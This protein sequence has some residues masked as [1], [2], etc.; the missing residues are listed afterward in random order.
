MSDANITN[1]GSIALDTITNDGTDITLDSSGDIVL[2]ADGA[3]IL[4][5]DDGTTFGALVND[6]GKLDIK[7]GSTPSTAI[8]IESDLKATF[9]ADVAVG[10]NMY[11]ASDAPEVRFGGSQEIKIIHDHDKGLILKHTATA[12][13]NLYHIYKQVKQILQQMM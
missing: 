2:D 7:S 13:I 5:K 12:M 8:S 10:D 9:T 1:I 6:S 3:D 4:L 11:F